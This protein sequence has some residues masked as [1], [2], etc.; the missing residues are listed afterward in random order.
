MTQKSVSI[1]ANVSIRSV[2]IRSYALYRN[3]EPA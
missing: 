2:T 1:R 3:V